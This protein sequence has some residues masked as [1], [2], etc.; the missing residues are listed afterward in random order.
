MSSYRRLLAKGGTLQIS[1]NSILQLNITSSSVLS[2]SQ[3][4]KGEGTE[5]VHD[6]SHSN[7]HIMKG[8]NY[9]GEKNCSLNI[10]SQGFMTNKNM[11]IKDFSYSSIWKKNFCSFSSSDI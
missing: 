3:D 4:K 6:G 5:G 1:A 7:P 8:E 10:K 9:F 11:T 2:G